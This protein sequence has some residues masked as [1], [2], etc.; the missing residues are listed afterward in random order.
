M[1]KSI[2]DGYIIYKSVGAIHELPLQQ[3]DQKIKVQRRGMLIPKIVGR[4]KMKSDKYINQMR[5]TPGMP[6]WQR[7]YY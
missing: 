5:G 7:N 6:V 2:A 1:A 3:N 4:F